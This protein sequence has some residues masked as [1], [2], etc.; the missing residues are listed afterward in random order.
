MR[1]SSCGEGE[2]H[3]ERK[4]EEVEMNKENQAL[5]K[6]KCGRLLEDEE[7][8]GKGRAA[9]REAQQGENKQRTGGS[10]QASVH[11]KN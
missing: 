3:G 10:H 7:G 9:E 5:T 11:Y 6:L 1:V 8:R 2:R 4:S